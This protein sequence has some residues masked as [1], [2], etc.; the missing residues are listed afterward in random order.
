MCMYIDKFSVS[1]KCLYRGLGL[2]IFSILFEKSDLMH[3]G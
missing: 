2:P 3:P 1:I